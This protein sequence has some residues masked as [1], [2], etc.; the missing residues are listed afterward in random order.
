MR[1]TELILL[2]ILILTS[3]TAGATSFGLVD[4]G[5]YYLNVPVESYK[6]RPFRTTIRQQ[7]D[8]SC[9]SAALA[10]LLTYHY[11]RKVSEREVFDAM[12]ALGDQ[13]KIQREGFS[14]LDIKRYLEAKGYRA[15]GYKAPLTQLLKVGVPA[16]VLIQ[17]NGYN[18]FV[19]VKGVTDSAVL[20]G[21]PSLGSRIIPRKR[22]AQL[23]TNGILFVIDDAKEEAVFNR[24]AEWRV[25]EMA[26]LS[27]AIS[28][29]G[30]ANITILTRPENDL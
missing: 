5:S 29:D 9:G 16:I 25:R 23:W 10:T 24:S 27:A 1:A 7:H 17:E 28:R 2:W 20:V 14:L 15:N 19:V 21:D 13:Q 11:D 18:H 26:P 6:E 3:G 30:L 8:Y 22:F 12:Y 4:L